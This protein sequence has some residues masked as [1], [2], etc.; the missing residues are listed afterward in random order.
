MVQEQVRLRRQGA[1]DCETSTVQ[2]IG[3]VKGDIPMRWLPRRGSPTL[4]QAAQGHS[5]EHGGGLPERRGPAL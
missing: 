4:H 3:A 5:G 2:F 1:N